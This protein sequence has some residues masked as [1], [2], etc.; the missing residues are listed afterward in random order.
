MLHNLGCEVL[1]KIASLLVVTAD[2][3]KK[4]AGDFALSAILFDTGSAAQAVPG[5]MAGAIRTGTGTECRLTG[6]G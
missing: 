4:T 1:I 2:S 6:T 3:D 5:R